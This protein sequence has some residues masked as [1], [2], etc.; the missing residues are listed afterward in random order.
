L[1]VIKPTHFSASTVSLKGMPRERFM[2]QS[3]V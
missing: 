2:I 1:K 3:Q